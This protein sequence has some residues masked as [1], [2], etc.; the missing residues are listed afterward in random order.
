MEDPL[1]KEEIQK[2]INALADGEEQ[3]RADRM[4]AIALKQ[5]K[6]DMEQIARKGDTR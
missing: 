6:E 2:A 5:A 4:I 1:D 3:R